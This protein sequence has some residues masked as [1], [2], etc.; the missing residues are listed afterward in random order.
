LI[1][2][3]AIFRIAVFVALAVFLFYPFETTV[4]PEWKF[5]VV[6]ESGNPVKGVGVKEG[7]RHYSVQIRRQ[8]ESLF[9]DDEGNVTFPRRTV[10]AGLLV[11]AVGSLI[12]ALNPH[13]RSGPHAFIDVQGSYSGTADYSPDKPIPPTL[14]VRRVGNDP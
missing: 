10:R 5:R 1:S 12:A 9:A 13:G 8:E 3:R 11:R 14:I 7:W 2:K 4:V 6:D